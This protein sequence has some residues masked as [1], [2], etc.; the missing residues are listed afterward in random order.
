MAKKTKKGAFPRVP[1]P[2]TT[3]FRAPGTKRI[4]AFERGLVN[5]IEESYDPDKHLEGR[6]LDDN[7]L[8]FHDGSY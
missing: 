8:D 3:K 5:W 6:W 1:E 7:Q 4:S 2:H